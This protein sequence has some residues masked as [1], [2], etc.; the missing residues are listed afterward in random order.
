MFWYIEKNIKFIDTLNLVSILGSLYRYQAYCIYISIPYQ[1]LLAKNQDF[2]Y[3]IPLY[4]YKNPWYQYHSS[5]L[6]AMPFGIGTTRKILKF[7]WYRALYL[8][9]WAMYRNLR[10]QMWL[11]HTFGCPNPLP[12]LRMIGDWSILAQMTL[13]T[14]QIM[15]FDALN[16]GLNK[17]GCL[18]Q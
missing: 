15:M 12:W 8:Y 13:M 1:Y 9:L 7:E 14:S 4:W 18:H 3:D 16:V 17:I 11:L 10:A 6:N 2:S 5:Y